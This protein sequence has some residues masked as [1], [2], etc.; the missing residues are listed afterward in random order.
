MSSILVCAALA[1]TS[2][3]AK[4]PHSHWRMKQGK[5]TQGRTCACPLQS[6][7]VARGRGKGEKTGR[8][9]PFLSENRK[10]PRPAWSARERRSKFNSSSD[11]QSSAGVARGRKAKEK[12]PAKTMTDGWSSC[13]DMDALSRSSSVSMAT[14]RKTMQRGPAD[15]PSK[16]GEGVRRRNLPQPQPSRGLLVGAQLSACCANT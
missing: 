14:T 8:C 3:L 9:N 6:A 7:I 16:H 12:Y 13:H 2:A 1:T 5:R 11:N 4:N 15:R 10:I